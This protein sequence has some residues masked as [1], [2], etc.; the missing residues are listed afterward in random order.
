MIVCLDV[1]FFYFFFFFFFYFFFFFFFV[2]I[3]VILIFFFFCF[4]FCFC[5]CF[6]VFVF[7]FFII[8][9]TFLLRRQYSHTN[10][11]GAGLHSRRLLEAMQFATVPVFIIDGY[12]PPFAS[13]LDWA[14]FSISIHP[15]DVSTLPSIIDAMSEESRYVVRPSKFLSQ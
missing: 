14:Q 3:F 5:F 9:I 15:T 13:L 4:C 12:V 7:V 2:I 11:Y 1:L 8:I 10:R 6:F